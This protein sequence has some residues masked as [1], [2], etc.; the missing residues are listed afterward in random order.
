MS[1]VGFT[2]FLGHASMGHDTLVAI[3]FPVGSFLADILNAHLICHEGAFLV[4]FL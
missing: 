4:D 3:I 1:S 2:Q